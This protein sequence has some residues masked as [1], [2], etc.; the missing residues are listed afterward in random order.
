DCAKMWPYSRGEPLS[1]VVRLKDVR[2]RPPI[3]KGHRAIKR[4]Q[5]W[6]DKQC[7]DRRRR[8]RL[9]LL[10]MTHRRDRVHPRECDLDVLAPR[11]RSQHRERFFR[12]HSRALDAAAGQLL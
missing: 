8:Y 4:V 5:L 6:L 11:P 9:A 7:E 3:L 10:Q 12:E 2:Q 1:A